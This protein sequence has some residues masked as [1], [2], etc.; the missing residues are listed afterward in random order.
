MAAMAIVAGLICGCAE[1]AKKPAVT[2]RDT[3]ITENEYCYYMSTYKGMFLATMG[4]TTDNPSY[5]A[6][7]IGEGIT[8]GDYVGALAANEVMTYAV[9]LQLFDE[10]GLSLTTEEINTVD[11]AI[12]AYTSAAGGKGAL[13]STL[14]SYNIDINMLREIKLDMVK[15]KKVQEYMMGEGDIIVTADADRDAYFKD[16]YKRVKYIFI[17]SQKDYVRE[18]DGSLAKNDDGSYKTRDITNT[19]K[20]EKA[21]LVEELKQRISDGEDFEALLNEYTMDVGMLHYP[22]GYYYTTSSGY[23]EA[24]VQ[25]ALTDAEVGEIVN[26]E[27]DAGWYIAKPYAL[28]EGAWKK[29]ENAA[30]FSNFEAMVNTIKLQEFLSS[31]GEEVV[32]A[33]G[34]VQAYP[35]AYCTP[36]VN[37]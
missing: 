12:N 27:T 1:E 23:V 33:D 29:E 14:T 35:L 16:A 13:N 21:V 20:A 4:Q 22:D 32:L 7:E 18:V 3:V 15:I 24:A 2:F 19:E 37:Y 9:M 17:S 8:V 34:I 30:M 11:S 6:T 5:W 26:V 31:F 36:N 10:Y 25:S 28:E